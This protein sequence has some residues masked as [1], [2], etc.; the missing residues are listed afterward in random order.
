MYFTD[1]RYLF[2]QSK[3]CSN[4]NY[5]PRNKRI[6][7]HNLIVLFHD[8]LSF[9][10]GSKWATHHVRIRHGSKR[11]IMGTKDIISLTFIQFGHTLLIDF[12]L[13]AQHVV[14]AWSESPAHHVVEGPGGPIRNKRYHKIRFAFKWSECSPWS[15]SSAHHVCQCLGS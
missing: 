6:N 14:V 1:E 5:S 12:K 8:W 7:S 4:Y 9:V 3:T 11:S 10:D 15:E 2:L 13:P